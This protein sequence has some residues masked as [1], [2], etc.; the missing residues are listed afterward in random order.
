MYKLKLNQIREVLGMEIKLEIVKL[1]DGVTEVEYEKLEPGFPVFVVAADG[2]TKSPAPAGEHTLEDGTEIEVDAAGIIME[3]SAPE[4]E[5][6]PVAT[7]DVVEVSAAEE[8]PVAEPVSVAMEDILPIIEEKVAEKMKM[9]FE[10][11]EEVANEVASIKEEMGAMKTK[12]EKFSKAPATS[13]A[14]KMTATA[15][16]IDSFESKLDFIKSLKK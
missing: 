9:I 11:V 4:V 14:S 2:V 6:A 15:E 13:A 16:K 8:A 10:V 5:E 3:V 1:V 7:E 12:M